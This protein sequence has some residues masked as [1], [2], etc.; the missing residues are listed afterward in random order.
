MITNCIGHKPHFRQNLHN[1][2]FP[3]SHTFENCS[4]CW[5]AWLRSLL[6]SLTVRRKFY[7]SGI[8]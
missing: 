3:V 1:H 2:L 8:L 5:H 4:G 6:I 7:D